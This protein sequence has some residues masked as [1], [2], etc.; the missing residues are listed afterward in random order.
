MQQLFFFTGDKHRSAISHMRN[1]ILFGQENA[2]GSVSK[3]FVGT[4]PPHLT[5]LEGQQT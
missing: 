4:M 3:P 2:I 1:K 5:L